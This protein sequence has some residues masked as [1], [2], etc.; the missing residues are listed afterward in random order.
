MF[1]TC[2]LE[3][4]VAELTLQERRT[5]ECVLEVFLRDC[6]KLLLF[7]LGCETLGSDDLTTFKATETSTVPVTWL[8]IRV[9]GCL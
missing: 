9:L 2:R 3:V 8:A 1:I 5:G 7:L 4:Y 6:S